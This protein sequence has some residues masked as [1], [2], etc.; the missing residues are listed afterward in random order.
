VALG[1]VL[2]EY[3]GFP[4]QSS[5]HQLLHNHPH[6]SSGVCTIGQKWPQYLVDLVP[7]HKIRKNCLMGILDT[8]YVH[9]MYIGFQLACQ[10][11][12]ERREV[13]DRCTSIHS[14]LRIATT[15]KYEKEK[16]YRC[17]LLYCASQT[18]RDF[19]VQIEGL[20]QPCVEQ[21]YGR[22]FSNNMRSLR[23]SVSHFGNFRNI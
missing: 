17:I 20:W 13:R 4:C 15:R 21:V 1:Q 18:L 10:V 7:P 23:V 3:F 9:G 2:S 8:G 16:M 11:K 22:N 19:F 6:L 14:S 5:F 12:Y